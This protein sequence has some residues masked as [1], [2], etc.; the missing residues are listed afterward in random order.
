[1]FHYQN[2][3]NKLVNFPEF[4]RSQY[5]ALFEDVRRH[6]IN[7]GFS[8]RTLYLGRR[9]VA[10]DFGDQEMGREADHEWRRHRRDSMSAS[11]GHETGNQ[12]NFDNF[13]FDDA[14]AARTADAWFANPRRKS[15]Y[16]EWIGGEALLPFL[17]LG[18]VSDAKALYDRLR[19]ALRPTT[20]YLWHWGP[21]LSF[22]AL[23]GDLDWGVKLFETL[24]P[25]AMGQSDLLS[26]FHFHEHAIVLFRQLAAE[27]PKQIRLRVPTSMQW[28]SPESHYEP[29]QILSWINSEA[30]EIARRFDERNGNA[31][32]AELLDRQRNLER[33]G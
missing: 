22:P 15:E 21:Y 19:R 11:V 13:M 28:Q 18:R 32:Y 7:H 33:H 25:I 6:C 9:S 10:L 29:A 14:A 1:L 5:E 16:D 23:T 4:P 17:R 30:V 2:V 8:L 27:R 12:I 26:R 31:F 20:G 3:I 24:L